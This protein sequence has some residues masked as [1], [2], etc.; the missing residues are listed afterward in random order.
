MA[1]YQDALTAENSATE[2]NREALEEA[3]KA[4]RDALLDA[5]FEAGLYPLEELAPTAEE[6]VEQE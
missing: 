6:S 3:A 4:A 5:L 2:E 1:A